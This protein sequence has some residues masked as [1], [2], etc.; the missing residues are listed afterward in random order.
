[1]KVRDYEKSGYKTDR[2][3]ELEKRLK[4]TQDLELDVRIK[5]DIA[6]KALITYKNLRYDGS[7]TNYGYI[8]KEALEKIKEI[9]R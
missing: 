1:M 6:I 9:K 4:D 5:L 2:E 7:V 8:A 3:I